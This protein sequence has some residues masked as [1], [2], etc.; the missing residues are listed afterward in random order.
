M[1]EG[2]RF[3]AAF[4]F[5]GIRFA[6]RQ[7]CRDGGQSRHLVSGGASSR[8]AVKIGTEEIYPFPVRW[9]YEK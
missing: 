4:R 2:C 5:C 9:Y 3:G 6:G 8:F 1:I 7:F